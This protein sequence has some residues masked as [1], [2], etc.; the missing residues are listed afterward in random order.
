[1]SAS[2]NTIVADLSVAL[3]MITIGLILNLVLVTSFCR[4]PSLRR[5]IPNILLFNQAVADLFSC[6][7]YGV[8]YVTFDLMLIF[9][10]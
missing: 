2:I 5:K 3:L 10:E 7:G 1:M 8:L 6:A 9:N 4:R